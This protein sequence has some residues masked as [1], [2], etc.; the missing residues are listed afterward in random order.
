MLC[1]CCA[2]A[3][4][5]PSSC[6]SS[7]AVGAMPILLWN[8][9]KHSTCSAYA[10]LMLRST[11]PPGGYMDRYA[12]ACEEIAYVLYILSIC[13]ANVRSR[14]DPTFRATYGSIFHRVVS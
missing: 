11:G 12:T 10:T 4:A 8:L 14:S 7:L 9:G 13:R 5:V 3:L 1:I 2:N 6:M